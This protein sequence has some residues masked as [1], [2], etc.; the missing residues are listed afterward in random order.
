MR[1][2][3]KRKVIVNGIYDTKSIVGFTIARQMLFCENLLC[4]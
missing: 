4:I 2:K 3:F 1:Q